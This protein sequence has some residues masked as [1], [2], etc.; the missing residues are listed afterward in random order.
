MPALNQRDTND[1]LLPFQGTDFVS[2]EDV[3]VNMVNDAQ[4]DLWGSVFLNGSAVVSSLAPGYNHSQGSSASTWTINH[5]L[6]Y[7]PTVQVFNAG[8]IQ[9]LAEI[10]NPT[11]NQTIVRIS[12]AQTGFARLV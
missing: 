6:G 10:E 9:V 5:N 2:N 1:H 4:L 11:I 8:S 7:K 12:P 3:S